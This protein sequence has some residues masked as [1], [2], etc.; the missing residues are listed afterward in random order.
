MSTGAAAGDLYETDFVSGTIF[1]FT[2]AGTPSIFASGLFAPE[3]LAF[4]SLGNLFVADGFSGTIFKFTP[5]GT[6]ETFAS[7]LNSPSGLA[8]DGSG[9]LFEVDSGSGGTCSGGT[10]FKFTPGGIKSTFASGL[11]N[12]QGLAFD[13][14]G[15]LFEA[16]RSGS[17]GT[18]YK[19]APNGTRI[20]FASGLSGPTFLAFAPT[21]TPISPTPTPTATLTPGKEATPVQKSVTIVVEKATYGR[22]EAIRAMI[23]THIQWGHD[24]ASWVDSAPDFERLAPAPLDDRQ[25]RVEKRAPPRCF[26]KIEL[27]VR[28]VDRPA[29]E[30]DGGAARVADAR[31]F[32]S[33]GEDEPAARLEHVDRGPRRSFDR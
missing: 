14:L 29:R 2:P 17:G 31:A 15:N 7:G 33:F 26:C 18:I 24:L 11:N 13:S 5:S 16:D 9:N 20:T 32:M 25:V 10:I 1:K 3:G 12:P 6:K 22:A 28:L 30:V 21:A 27:A 19:F 23:R 4:D 8:F